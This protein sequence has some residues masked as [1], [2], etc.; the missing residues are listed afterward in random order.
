MVFGKVLL[1]NNETLLLS[2][3]VGMTDFPCH[4]IGTIVSRTDWVSSPSRTH[5]T[6]DSQT[7]IQNTME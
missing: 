3:A 5:E 7:T 4:S 2:G 1:G 6:M